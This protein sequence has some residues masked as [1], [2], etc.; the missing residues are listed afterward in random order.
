MSAVEVPIQQIKELPALMG[1]G[2]I[3]KTVQLLP[4][5]QSG[6]EGNAGLYVRGGPDQN[7]VLLDEAVVYNASHLFGSSQCLMLMQ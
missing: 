1:E 3:I 5:V 2:D 4:G 7:L 6:S